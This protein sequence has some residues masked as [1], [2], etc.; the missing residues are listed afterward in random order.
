MFKSALYGVGYVAGACA[1]LIAINEARIYR[2][3]IMA[4]KAKVCEKICRKK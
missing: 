1:G 4:L 2:P 3:Q